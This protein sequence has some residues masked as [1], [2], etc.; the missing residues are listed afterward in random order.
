[1]FFRHQTY[2]LD[3][4]IKNTCYCERRI[5]EVDEMGKFPRYLHCHIIIFYFENLMGTE[6]DF[7]K[8]FK[9]G[10]IYIFYPMWKLLEFLTQI[11]TYFI[12]VFSSLLKCKIIVYILF[13]GV[14]WN[15][16]RR[17]VSKEILWVYSI[18]WTSVELAIFINIK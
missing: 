9:M 18:K 1:M 12:R 16:A 4:L 2:S 7:L 5:I 13:L 17:G 15:L 6:I 8:R 10:N 11:F 3:I 14:N